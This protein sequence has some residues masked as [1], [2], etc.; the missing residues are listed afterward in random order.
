MSQEENIFVDAQTGDSLSFFLDSSVK[1]RKTIQGLIEKGGGEIRKTWSENVVHLIEDI[2]KIPSVDHEVYL[3]DFIFE[4]VNNKELEELQNYLVSNTKKKIQK[5]ISEAPTSKKT[6]V[7]YTEEEDEAI[8]QFV[9][10]HRN[11]G[12]PGGNSL[13]HRMEEKKITAH[14]WASMRD[15]YNKIL[16]PKL[17]E[18]ISKSAQQNSDNEDLVPIDEEV[19]N[20]VEKRKRDN[21]ESR[22][23]SKTQEI[24]QNISKETNVPIP[25]VF[26]ALFVYSGDVLLAVE[27]LKKSGVGCC[28]KPWTP[29]EDKKITFGDSPEELLLI[30]QEKSGPYYERRLK[31]LEEGQNN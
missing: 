5:T 14:T 4:S 8:I 17:E 3:V 31:F 9:K 20:K 24:I 27:Y 13:W 28:V 29:L 1:K 6:K 7:P 11:L 18:K 12:S 22:K 26:H 30:A 21:E 15:R 25:V 10:N 2:K 16:V 19:S 23:I